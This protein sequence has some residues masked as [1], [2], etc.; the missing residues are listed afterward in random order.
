MDQRNPAGYL[1]WPPLDLDITP[2]VRS[3]DN[4]VEIEI[5]GSLRNLL[6][7]HHHVEA[8]PHFTGPWHF[9]YGENWTDS[10]H[11]VPF[12]IAGDVRV[13]MESNGK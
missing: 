6:G 13:R 9:E 7:P 8:D 5:V 10:Y 4:T 11:F 2:W 3:G 1:A 12:G